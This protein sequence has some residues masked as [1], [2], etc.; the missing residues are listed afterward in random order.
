MTDPLLDLRSIRSFMYVAEAG[1]FT[2]AAAQLS[3]AQ[4]ALSRQVRDLEDELGVLLL[5]RTG[6]GAELTE[7]GQR[8]LSRAKKLLLN[9]SALSA[10]MKALSGANIETVTLG[11]PPSISHILLA[12]LLDRVKRQ[13]PHI[14][15]RV[16]E[17]FSGHIYEWLLSSTLPILARL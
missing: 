6:R 1:S 2:R 7:A 16:V 12:L 5:H 13:Y 14:R 17:G 15:M 9:A 10:D 11:V 4:S 8:F 3:M